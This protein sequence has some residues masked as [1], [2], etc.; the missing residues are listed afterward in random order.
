MTLSVDLSVT[1]TVNTERFLGK[2][3]GQRC[4][5]ISVRQIWRFCSVALE[6]VCGS[7]SLGRT[8]VVLGFMLSFSEVRRV[9]VRNEQSQDSTEITSGYLWSRPP[10]CNT[11]EKCRVLSLARVWCQ[12][13]MREGNLRRGIALLTPRTT[14]EILSFSGGCV[15]RVAD[16]CD[17]HPAKHY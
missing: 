14:Y 11:R 12:S 15:R 9:T 10:K 3:H 16:R 5:C 8:A 7:S 17:V 2:L 1:P 6:G 4:T 13:I